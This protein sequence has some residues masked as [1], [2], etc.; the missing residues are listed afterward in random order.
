MR[1]TRNDHHIEQAVCI[2]RRLASCIIRGTITGICEL[3]MASILEPF[4]DVVETLCGLQPCL[5]LGH[6]LCAF[7][8]FTR[9]YIFTG[10]TGA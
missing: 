10:A 6:I 7:K 1:E 4:A 2:Y 9:M 5:S 3:T 8:L